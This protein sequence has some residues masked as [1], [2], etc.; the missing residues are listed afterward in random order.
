MS[1]SFKTAYNL[2]AQTTEN[3]SDV[4]V[5]CSGG[6]DSLALAAVTYRV[7][8][9]QNFHLYVAIV[10]HQLQP[11][12]T[13]V[14]ERT[15][16]MFENLWLGQDKTASKKVSHKRSK[17]E[18]RHSAIPPFRHTI[19]SKNS[20]P[21]TP[22]TTID[23]NADSIA[24]D[25]FSDAESTLSTSEAG[26]LIPNFDVLQQNSSC[27]VK[28][29]SA[30]VQRNSKLGVEAEARKV[31]YQALQEFAE[32]VNSDCVLLGH[33]END[34]AETVLLGLLRGSGLKSISGMPAQRGI[35][36][37]PF[38]SGVTRADTEKICQELGWEYWNDPMEGLRGQVRHQLLPEFAKVA[39]KP[40]VSNLANTA[41]ILQEADQA[42][43]I[44]AEK[45]MRYLYQDSKLKASA[46]KD[47]PAG[48]R[49]RIYASIL[50]SVKSEEQ[51]IVRAHLDGIDQLVIDWHGQQAIQVPNFNVFRNEGYIYFEKSV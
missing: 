9:K 6:A 5:A 40:L 43:D 29:L 34:Q 7:S 11:E 36:Y 27:I 51:D 30:Q 38:L 24:A 10:D 49:K 41:L 32:S 2:V 15:K 42:L 33:T 26:S 1:Q 19:L 25:T 14:A 31:R 3:H 50:K 46:L 18:E 44:I 35:F 45:L 17:L 48:I 21:V 47:Q 4:V 13:E 39:G 23:A 37:R 22:S 8:H 28:V 16:K 20:D 12:S